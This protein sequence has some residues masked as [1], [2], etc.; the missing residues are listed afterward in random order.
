MKKYQKQI[1]EKRFQANPYLKEE[2]E[3]QF[4]RLLNVS[5]RRIEQWFMNKRHYAKSEVFICKGD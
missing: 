1:L 3:H 2:E 5:K 4:S